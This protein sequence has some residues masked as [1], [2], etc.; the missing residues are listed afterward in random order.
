M[1]IGDYKCANMQIY[2]NGFIFG[3]NMNQM[4][5]SD[6]HLKYG[7][8]YIRIMHDVFQPSEGGNN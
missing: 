5:G 8:I 6:C 1:I 2:S 7:Q 4:N 3:Q